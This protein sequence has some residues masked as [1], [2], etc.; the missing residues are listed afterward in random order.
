[1]W[2]IPQSIRCC[3]TWTK[4]AVSTTSVLMHLAPPCRVHVIRPSETGPVLLKWPMGPRL[5]RTWFNSFSPIQTVR[6]PVTTSRGNVANTTGQVCRAHNIISGFGT[7]NPSRST[8]P[9]NAVPVTG[10]VP[11]ALMKTDVC[12]VAWLSTTATLAKC[13]NS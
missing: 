13:T 7:G 9:T 3:L 6:G 8:F 10:G 12:G 5:K 2:L 11:A 4:L 1:M